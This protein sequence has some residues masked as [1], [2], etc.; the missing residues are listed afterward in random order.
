MK[1]RL[2]IH[3]DSSVLYEHACDISD[4]ETFGK[5]C[6]QAWM[7]LREQRLARATSIGALF[8]ELNDQLLDELNGAK[9][10]LTKV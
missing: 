5:A 6:S 1:V 8:E 9:L 10:S 3:K 4:A 7:Q 2:T